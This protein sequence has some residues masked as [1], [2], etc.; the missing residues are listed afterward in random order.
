MPAPASPELEALLAA[1][2]K[3]CKPALWSQGVT[4]ARA[5]A[6][7]VESSSADEIVLRVRAPGKVVPLTA[8]LYPTGGEWECDC[9]SR[10]SPCEHVA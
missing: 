10:M 4:M 5:D 6:V 8:V 7:A 1:I 3:R 9:P 2:R